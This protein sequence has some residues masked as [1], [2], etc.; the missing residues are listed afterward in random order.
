MPR[1]WALALVLAACGGSPKATTTPTPPPPAEQPAGPTCASA[2]D[3][4]I[5]LMT[6]LAKEAPP[7]KVKQFK[8]SF[9]SHCDQDG[10]SVEMR[11]CVIDAH[12]QDDFEKCDGFMTAEQKASLAKESEGTKGAGASP[13][14]GSPAPPGG[15]S[16]RGPSGKGGDPCE[17][18]E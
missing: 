11:K 9:V 3:H 1:S 8:D 7:E 18:G 4:V 13:P 14:G 16:Q 15:D 17:G 12:G 10:W 2:A 5:D 6:Q